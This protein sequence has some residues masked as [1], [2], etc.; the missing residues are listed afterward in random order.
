MSKTS[1]EKQQEYKRHGAPARF[2]VLQ[3]ESKT[4][5]SKSVPFQK[6]P[7]RSKSTDVDK[8]RRPEAARE[9]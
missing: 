1:L 3:A 9:L 8:R 6:V 7:L 2:A 5:N 4:S